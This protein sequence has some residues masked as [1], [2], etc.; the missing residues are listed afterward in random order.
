MFPN[1][2]KDKFVVKSGS[3]AI[4]NVT[5][6]SVTGK[7]L[8]SVNGAEANEVNVAQLPSGYYFVKVTTNKGVATL[9]LVKE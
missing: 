4:E 5:V 7:Q 2:A 9:K 3:L 8:V 1:P 6:L